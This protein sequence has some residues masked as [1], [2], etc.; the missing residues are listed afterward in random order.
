MNKYMTIIFATI[1]LM[2]AGMAVMNC[3]TDADCNDEQVCTIDQCINNTC[4]YDQITSCTDNDGCCP[5]ECTANTDN[6]CSSGGGGGGGCG[7]T[8]EPEVTCNDGLDNDCDGLIDMDDPDCANDCTSN[9]DCDDGNSCTIDQ[10]LNGICHLTDVTECTSGDG[11]CPEECTQANDDDCETGENTDPIAV[12]EQVTECYV[13]QLCTF[14]GSDSYDPDGTITSHG[15]DLGNGGGFAAPGNPGTFNQAYNVAGPYTL[16]LSVTDNDNATS[17]TFLSI[18][19]KE[20]MTAGYDLKIEEMSCPTSPAYTGQNYDITAKVYLEV[21]GTEET[22]APVQYHIVFCHGGPTSGGCGIT[23]VTDHEPNTYK[24]FTFNWVPYETG[25]HNLSVQ[26]DSNNNIDETN[27]NNND[28]SCAIEVEESTNNP[29]QIKVVSPNGGETWKD[30]QQIQWTTSDPDGSV[31]AHVNIYS[32]SQIN[33]AVDMTADYT[34]EV[35]ASNTYGLCG[36]I[37]EGIENTEE[38]NWDTTTVPNGEY[39]IKIQVTDG[40]LWASDMSDNYFK[41]YN[42]ETQSNFDECNNGI[43]YSIGDERYSSHSKYCHTGLSDCCGWYQTAHIHDLKTAIRGPVDLH[44]TFKPGFYDGC[45]STATIS[46]SLDDMT[47][48]EVARIPVKSVDSDGVPGYPEIWKRY[49]HTLNNIESFRYVKIEIPKCYNDY[50]SVKVDKPGTT[51]CHSTYLNRGFKLNQGDCAK[52][53]DYGK[54]KI[55]LLDVNFE[56][57]PTTESEVSPRGTVVIQVEKTDGA[58]I[59]A[60]K[61]T[62]REGESKEVFGATIKNLGIYGNTVAAFMV[63]AEGKE[64]KVWLNRPF[65][66]KQSQTARLMDYRVITMQLD[67]IRLMPYLKGNPETVTSHTTN[68]V[69][70]RIASSSGGGGGTDS[71]E[72]SSSG[73]SGGGGIAYPSS[74]SGGGSGG[75]INIENK[76][77]AYITVMP[78]LERPTLVNPTIQKIEPRTLATYTV[79]VPT[80]IARESSDTTE[81][82]TNTMSITGRT[83]QATIGEEIATVEKA[84]NDFALTVI[85]PIRTTQTSSGIVREA[86]AERLVQKEMIKKDLGRKHRLTKG[87][88]IVEFGVRITLKDINQNYATLV[89]TK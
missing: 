10:C 31:V 71:G 44:L 84:I 57:K 55:T 8:E 79:T 77:V 50:S 3:S 34:K 82:V 20:N 6:D 62:L 66:I 60:I 28:A 43:G 75:V 23:A 35:T 63:N 46:I 65:D 61:L 5:E 74:S 68:A 21:I 76:Y 25:P 51:P 41:I 72:A 7:I 30:T 81:S 42:E 45:S 38:Y 9:S 87:D 29:P 70:A 2:S 27:E 26:V 22:D 83:V 80:P 58:S 33:Y 48:R 88:S 67:S 52:I 18:T 1:F 69:T 4:N 54:M 36:T 89:M 12:L 39:K 78:T 59:G 53:I 49:T 16:T 15:V 73:G 11:C 19:V 17:T 37:A 32:C 56:N 86:E 13:E 40:G 14:D 24:T 64:I 47:W 85:K